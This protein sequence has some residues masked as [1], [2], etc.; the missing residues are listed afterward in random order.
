MSKIIFFP[1]QNM[2]SQQHPNDVFLLLQSEDVTDKTVQDAFEQADPPPTLM[3]VSLRI[4]DTPVARSD[5]KL[6][7]YLSR[8]ALDCVWRDSDR[9]D[10]T[11]TANAGTSVSKRIYVTFW[12]GQKSNGIR[13]LRPLMTP[14]VSREFDLVISRDNQVIGEVASNLYATN[15]SAAFVPLEEQYCAQIASFGDPGTLIGFST[16]QAL[17]ALRGSGLV[18]VEMVTDRED[19]FQSPFWYSKFLRGVSLWNIDERRYNVVSAGAEVV[20]FYQKLQS[21]TVNTA[22]APFMPMT[23]FSFAD[24]VRYTIAPFLSSSNFVSNISDP[25]RFFYIASKRTGVVMTVQQC[26]LAAGGADLSAITFAQLPVAAPSDINGEL[27]VPISGGGI[28]TVGAA[29]G[30]PSG[31]WRG[32]SMN[33]FEWENGLSEAILTTVNELP[34]GIDSPENDVVPRHSYINMHAGTAWGGGPGATT[35][36]ERSIQFDLLSE[37]FVNK[38]QILYPRSMEDYQPLRM[39]LSAQKVYGSNALQSTDVP[40]AVWFGGFQGVSPFG[41]QAS[42]DAANEYANLNTHSQSGNTLYGNSLRLVDANASRSPSTHPLSGSVEE[43]VFATGT[44]RANRTGLVVPNAQTYVSTGANVLNEALDHIRQEFGPFVKGATYEDLR[45]PLLV[46]AI[47]AGDSKTAQWATQQFPN[48]HY[49]TDIVSFFFTATCETTF[50]RGTTFV[51]QSGFLVPVAQ[52]DLL[53]VTVVKYVYPVNFNDNV[54]N[55]PLVRETFVSVYDFIMSK[56]S[57]YLTNGN[58]SNILDTDVP[59]K[60]YI[61]KETY[62]P[63]PAY[64][65]YDLESRT[66]YSNRTNTVRPNGSLR[67]QK[68]CVPAYAAGRFFGVTCGSALAGGLDERVARGINGEQPR[69]FA[70]RLGTQL[71]DFTASGGRVVESGS[72]QQARFLKHYTGGV[73]SACSVQ[74]PGQ[75]YSLTSYTNPDVVPYI[76]SSFAYVDGDGQFFDRT[77]N[78]LLEQAGALSKSL[79]EQ[80]MPLSTQSR[81]SVMTA[82]MVDDTTYDQFL[83]RTTASQKTPLRRSAMF[84]LTL[85]PS[86]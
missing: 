49:F 35:L 48:G 4:A 63:A 38:M 41:K 81:E 73:L 17:T 50:T 45:N 1:T 71:F 43:P 28:A 77:E 56:Y 24:P 46:K 7:V 15:Q 29:S 52:A 5:A 74:A 86:N 39:G 83:Y 85:R 12:V 78:L 3:T 67:P 66:Q 18:T 21:V 47:I 68:M 72:T 65:Q 34:P 9:P 14:T 22:G 30:I 80:G 11:M 59:Q 36:S 79:V 62:Y 20:K 69:L 40:R 37:T 51:L 19:G 8:Y 33:A 54:P 64:D 84:Q 2:T 57:V 26:A 27:R 60:D 23:F 76:G 58:P 31:V 75:R 82:N 32:Q 25:E 44:G 55:A 16:A 10:L 13:L 70:I 42:S 61:V 6:A 53:D